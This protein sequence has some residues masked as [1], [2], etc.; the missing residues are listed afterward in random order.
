M[1]PIFCGCDL[2]WC[3]VKIGCFNPTNMLHNS[4]LHFGLFH[5]II[6]LS[7]Q[8]FGQLNKFICHCSQKLNSAGDLHRFTFKGSVTF[9]D[10][11]R[12]NHVH[13]PQ[14]P[15]DGCPPLLSDELQAENK[16]Y[17]IVLNMY[18]KVLINEGNDCS[19]EASLQK[20]TIHG[21]QSQR[22][23][24]SFCPYYLKQRTDTFSDPPPLSARRHHCALP[25]KTAHCKRNQGIYEGLVCSRQKL[26]GL[27]RGPSS[28]RN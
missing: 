16:F 6:T 10:C 9:L 21:C 5:Q 7:R 26:L 18:A 19:Q 28:L 8:F 1:S 4:F 12:Q 24:K 2:S 14:G 23:N 13:I 22:A 27:D 11:F 15:Y 17:Y 20:P 25:S 3:G